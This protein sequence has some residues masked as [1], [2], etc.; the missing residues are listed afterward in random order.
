MTPDEQLREAMKSTIAFQSANRSLFDEINK[1]LAFVAKMNLEGIVP[2]ITKD[3]AHIIS[4]QADIAKI[5]PIIG[6]PIFD[7]SKQASLSISQG[8]SQQ[9]AEIARLTPKLS[10][11]LAGQVSSLGPAL[12]AM[13]Q[14][15]IQSHF[16]RVSEI[17]LLAQK[18]LAGIEFKEIAKALS[19]ADAVRESFKTVHLGFAEQYSI[20]F[21]SLEQERA[22]V[23]SFL[24]DLTYL[25]AVEFYR[26]SRIV[27][28]VTLPEDDLSAD[29][30]L[31]S[32]DIST[33]SAGI[34]EEYLKHINPSLIKLWRGASQALKSDNPDSVRHFIASLREL[35]T[36][37]IHSLSPDIEIRAWTKAPEHYHNNRPTR[38]AR[39]LYI[40]RE[41]NHKPFDGFLE[42]DI[43]SVLASFDMFQQGTH[44]VEAPFSEQQLR[45]LQIRAESTIRFLI[46]LSKRT[47][48]A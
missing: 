43:D 6:S 5:R 14:L 44:Q 46:D 45:T 42:K 26:G 8:L 41:I 31:I 19:V 21:R 33:E 27:R 47:S 18:S 12:G 38:R 40:C 29:E 32:S 20:L 23:S 48:G 1:S 4:L 39:L 17:S 16:A 34:V 35:L 37:V 11:V 13:N 25:P 10:D 28:T 30:D 24:S 2:K 3:F 9:I 22:R 36:H 15:A 7:F